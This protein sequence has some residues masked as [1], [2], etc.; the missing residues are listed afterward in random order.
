MRPEPVYD[1]AEVSGSGRLAG[2]TAIITGGDSGI[3]R[4]VAV[5]FAKEG[6]DVIVLYLKE[7]RDAKLTREIVEKKYHRSCLLVTGD[8]NNEKF[9]ISAIKKSVKNFLLLTFWSTMLRCSMSRVTLMF[10]VTTVL[11]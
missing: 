8:I 11:L 6:A 9:C 3:G 7:H 4:A 5:L 10:P 2:K 1:Y